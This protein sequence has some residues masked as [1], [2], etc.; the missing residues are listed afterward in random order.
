MSVQSAF[1][2]KKSLKIESEEARIEKCCILIL[3]ILRLK[4]KHE[5][6]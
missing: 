1:M 2:N 5:K 3:S 4:R 6:L